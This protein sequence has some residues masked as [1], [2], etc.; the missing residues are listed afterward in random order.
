LLLMSVSS[1]VCEG[2]IPSPSKVTEVCGAV[3]LR[4]DPSHN[5]KQATGRFK[6]GH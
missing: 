2:T 5:P 4:R 1:F 6:L 3:R